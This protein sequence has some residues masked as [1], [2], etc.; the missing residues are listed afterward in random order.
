M[1]KKNTFPEPT[2]TIPQPVDEQCTSLLATGSTPFILT[3]ILLRLLQYHFADAINITNPFLQPYIWE[4][5]EDPGDT[6]PESKIFI[7][8]DYE[9]NHQ[10]VGQRPALFVSRRPMNTQKVGF[11]DEVVPGIGKPG[12]VYKGHKH[13]IYLI[14]AHNIVC[15]GQTG[16]EAENLAEEV[17]FRMLHYMPV[18]RE[19][20]R[21]GSF[22]VDGISETRERGEDPHKTFVVFVRMSWS[23]EHRWMIIPET[24]VLKRLGLVFSP[25]KDEF[26]TSGA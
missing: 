8:V 23:T 19:D 15:V 10:V 18:I 11:K 21:I 9:R 17:F 13:Q 3:G 4:E 7:G 22:R 2:W 20:I 5:G 12:A 16:A 1:A 6:S 14:G 25:F 26:I 24:P